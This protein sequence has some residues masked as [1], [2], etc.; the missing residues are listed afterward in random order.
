MRGRRAVVA[1]RA[2][3]VTSTLSTG[4]DR[5]PR[6]GRD[7]LQISEIGVSRPAGHHDIA[8]LVSIKAPTTTGPIAG[9]LPVKRLFAGSGPLRSLPYGRSTTA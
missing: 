7:P 4:Y 5:N 3:S 1:T 8:D 9:Q 2:P 6:W